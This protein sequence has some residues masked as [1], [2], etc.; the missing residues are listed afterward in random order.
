MLENISCREFFLKMKSS[1]FPYP[2]VEASFMG[3]SG[4]EWAEVDGSGKLL[5]H[6]LRAC[7]GRGDHR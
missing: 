4:E 7:P 5:R 1:D 3:V 6:T 2:M